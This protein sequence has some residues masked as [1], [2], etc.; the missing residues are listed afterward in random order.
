MLVSGNAR[1]HEHTYILRMP[2]WG[3][4]SSNTFVPMRRD[5]KPK[6]MKMPKFEA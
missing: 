2:N 5:S 1:A 6:L 3:R 4:F